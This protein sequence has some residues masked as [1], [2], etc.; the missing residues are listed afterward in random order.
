MLAAILSLTVLPV[1]YLLLRAVLRY[2]QDKD[3]PPVIAA[4]IPFITPYVGLITKGMSYF[5]FLRARH[6]LPVYTLRFPGVRAY[7]INTPSLALAAHRPS[8]TISWG[9]ILADVAANMMG[10]GRPTVEVLRKDLGFDGNFMKG[11]HQAM[12]SALSP[13]MPELDRLGEAFSLAYSASLDGDKLRTPVGTTVR[14]FEFLKRHSTNGMTE[15]VFGPHNPYHDPKMEGYYNAMELALFPILLGL[16]P[17]TAKEGIQGRET[18]V[19][20]YIKYFG[21]GGHKDPGASELLRSR[22]NFF[23]SYGIPEHEIARIEVILTATLLGNSRPTTFWLVWHLVSDQSLL[24]LCREELFAAMTNNDPDD[25]DLLV[26]NAATIKTRCP[27]LFSTLLE[28]FRFHG[29][30]M[31][32]RKVVRNHTLSGQYKLK[33]GGYLVTPASVQHSGL[34]DWGPRSDVFDAKRFITD[35]KTKYNNSAFKPWGHGGNICPGRHFATTA[36]LAKA[37]MVI[38]RFDITPVAA[39][40]AGHKSGSRGWVLPQSHQSPVI[41]S[42]VPNDDLLMLWSRSVNEL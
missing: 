16:G 13:K 29:N 9:P 22:Y 40:P 7:V 11:F 35:G 36:V 4:G 34:A 3:E 39:T 21:I 41:G 37:A 25:A 14:M 1:L 5:V 19:R 18:L 32:V 26:L 24:E 12:H 33:A 8:P 10:L 38:L 17:L 2:T 6:D 30:N 15:A 28:V 31:S 42:T 23:L 20:A 27:T